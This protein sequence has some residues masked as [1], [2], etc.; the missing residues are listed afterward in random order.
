MARCHGCCFCSL[1]KKPVVA[2]GVLATWTRR[3]VKA[4]W[5]KALAKA[6]T[7]QAPDPVSNSSSAGRS[8]CCRGRISTKV[9]ACLCLLSWPA[10]TCS[11]KLHATAWLLGKLVA[12]YS[13]TCLACKHL[14]LSS[15]LLLEDHAHLTHNVLDAENKLNLLCRNWG[16]CRRH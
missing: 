2:W 6:S 11:L 3:Q 7:T 5:A 9:S 13:N 4:I 8:P 10:Q 15:H 14:R 16:Q 12:A 1:N